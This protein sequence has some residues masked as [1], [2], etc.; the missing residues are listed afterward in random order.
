MHDSSFAAALAL[1]TELREKGLKIVF[2]ESCTAGLASATLARIPGISEQHCGSAVVYRLDTKHEW[3]G[4]SRGLLE[5]PGPVSKEVAEAMATG[6]LKKT[7]EADI[8]AAITGHLGP[9]A[10]A[11]QDGLIWMAVASRAGSPN[12][13]AKSTHLKWMERDIR[14]IEA[15]EHLLNYAAEAVTRL[16]STMV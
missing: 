4:V 3:L 1:A 10:P 2:A 15:A 13:S 16:P 12:V 7:P 6:V 8:A 14:Q 9:N 5:D 11:G